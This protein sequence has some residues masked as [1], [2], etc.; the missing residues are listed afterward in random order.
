M[1]DNPNEKRIKRVLWK[2]WKRI[3]KFFNTSGLVY[4][5]LNLKDKLPTMSEDEMIKLLSTNGKLIK[6]P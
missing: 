4:R 2:K 5:E 1:T 6:R 3:K